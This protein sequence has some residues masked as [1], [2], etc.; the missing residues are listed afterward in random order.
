MP[1]SQPLPRRRLLWSGL[2]AIAALVTGRRA[3]AQ[4]RKQLGEPLTTHMR[5]GEPPVQ[6]LDTMLLY[7]RGDDSNGRAMTHEVLSLIHQEKGKRSFPWT[8][9]ASLETH[10]EEGDACVVCSRLHKHGPG[11]SA[12][13]HSEVF[14]H[15]RAVALGANI[16]MSSDYAGSE[17]TQVIGLNIQ[18]VKGP[19]RMQYG[20]QVHE[21]EGRFEKAIGLNGTGDVGLDLGGKFKTGVHAHGNSIRVDEGTCIE[22]DGKGAIRVRYLNGR[23]EFLNGDRCFGHLDV[24]GPDHAL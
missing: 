9:Y 21:G 15:A 5:Q 14:N 3:G 6:P 11:W 20:I 13:L 18:A 19:R 22:L 2:G 16:E 24:N 10:H 1:D 8:L 12:G 23:I 7:E 17:P 4:V